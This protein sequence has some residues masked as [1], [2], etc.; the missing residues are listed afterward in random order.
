MMTIVTPD[1]TFSEWQRRSQNEAGSF[2]SDVL[3]ITSKFEEVIQ[4]TQQLGLPN[5]YRTTVCCQ[6]FVEALK[7]ST[8]GAHQELMQRLAQELLRSIFADYTEVEGKG[9][10]SAREGQKHQP[11]VAEC[12]DMTIPYFESVVP[13]QKEL[14]SKTNQLEQLM[15]F[16]SQYSIVLRKHQHLLTMSIHS[17][18]QNLVMLAFTSWVALLRIRQAQRKK[19]R[20]IRQQIWFTAWVRRVPTGEE[21]RSTTE[22]LTK[23]REKYRSKCRE[24]ERM[25]TRF[26]NLVQNLKDMRLVGLI[27][28]A[29]S[30]GVSQR[31][32]LGAQAVVQNAIGKSAVRDVHHHHYI[33]RDVQREGISQHKHKEHQH[34]R[35]GGGSRAAGVETDL[36]H[37]LMVG[38]LP[39]VPPRPPPSLPLLLPHCHA[40]ISV[41]EAALTPR[42]SRCHTF[43]KKYPTTQN[44][45]TSFSTQ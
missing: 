9:R 34:T 26:Q 25:M 15:L 45:A 39:L 31:T 43:A 32:K 20:R 7:I 11:T 21:D 42:A 37:L 23:M 33:R 22:K 36:Q 4:N 19:F 5:T 13:L 2:H 14:T 41:L 12:H 28:E 18:Q 10:G 38:V 35:R 1:I 40:T 24:L 30:G 27:E 3:W 16:S 17:W 6:L 8:H 44:W 29:R